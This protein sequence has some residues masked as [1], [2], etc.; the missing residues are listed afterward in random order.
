MKR[1]LSF[2]TLLLIFCSTMFG[3]SHWTVNENTYNST[4]NVTT[5]AEIYGELQN[6]A[7]TASLEIAAFCG[8]EVRGVAN[9]EYDPINLDYSAW[10]T[11]HGDSQKDTITFKLYDHSTDTEYATDYMLKYKIGAVEYITINFNSYIPKI[12][13]ETTPYQTLEDAVAAAQDG[14][15]I[16][17]LRD[18]VDKGVV[19]NKNITIDFGGFTYTVNE[20][21]GSTDAEHNGFL[22]QNNCEVALKNG[23]L[24]VNEDDADK[25]NVLIHNY[26]DLTVTDMT[27]DGKFLDLSTADASYVISNKSGT[28]NLVGNTNI[29]ANDEGTAF[30]L[31][32]C[33]NTADGNSLPHVTLNT[34]GTIK[35]A[36]ELTASLD[37]SA[38]GDNSEISY[39]ALNGNGQLNH[40]P[41][42]ATIIKRNIVGH[43]IPNGSVNYADGWFSISSPII[44]TVSHENV[45]NLLN[46]THDLY[47]YNE[48]DELWENVEVENNG[49]NT[50]D[51]GRGYLYA[52]EIDT[53][54][55][56]EGTLNSV[57]TA[58]RLSASS[59]GALK[60]FNL[61]GNPYTHNITLAHITG[62]DLVDG[63]YTLTNEGAWNAKTSSDAIGACQGVLVKTMNEADAVIYEVAPTKR[64]LE[65]DNGM[66]AITV[67][68][69]SYSDVAYA[70]FNK[71][72]GLDK[73]G[74]RN[75][76]IPM[77]YI[78]VDGVN[79][80][81]AMVDMNAT[82]IPVSFEAMTMG[83]YSISAE[84][85][86]CE[87]DQIILV[88]RFT[89]EETDLLHEDYSF[90]ASSKDKSERF[91]I[92]LAASAA[93]A[94]DNFAYVN[95]DMLII[96]KIA[97]QGVVS[98]YD[99]A[100]RNI[101]E[102]K[103]SDSA[104]I[105]LASLRKG[106]YLIQMSDASGI[107]VQKII[108]D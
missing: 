52:N 3:Q 34:T 75:M 49:F 5:Y 47:R 107:K 104:N 94:D 101:A 26:A 30:A 93:S 54:L 24:N 97:G 45:T 100:G 32:A 78:P 12:K 4:M 14:Q 91:V 19:I 88:D 83:E 21:V 55:S 99:V 98:V 77:V 65:N 22:I 84:A 11:I 61:I 6:G 35:G 40:Y 81:V 33:D 90:I 69:E 95:N 87:F 48:A 28:V 29:Y 9:I 42:F 64:T 58:Q 57:S 92:R 20:G 39:I 53:E 2:L 60:G 70:S 13:I 8:N 46:G 82:E 41:G 106:V 59:D 50:L 108:I 23:S 16:S 96:N 62:A 37:I 25:L 36:V 63:F 68:N 44:G 17:V 15:T 67:S 66:L 85:R 1:K 80:A 72:L 51:A 38:L 79:Y 31:D 102:Y 10:M 73:I 7:S 18:I 103:V 71:G 86:D 76:E 74:H 43:P 89:G 105:P 27:L 56:F